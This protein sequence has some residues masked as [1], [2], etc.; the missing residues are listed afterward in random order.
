MYPEAHH[1]NKW[2]TQG[3]IIIFCNISHNVGPMWECD[4]QVHNT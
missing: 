3:N 2:S 1:N 4:V